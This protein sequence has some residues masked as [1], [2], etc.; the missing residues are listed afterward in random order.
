[1]SIYDFKVKDTKGAEVDLSEYKGK[2]LLLNLIK[3]R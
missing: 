3:I 2:V 1:M